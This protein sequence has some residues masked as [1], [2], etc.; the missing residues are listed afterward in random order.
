M[1]SPSI[2]R[3]ATKK[4]R[5]EIWR[6]LRLLHSENGL[7]DLSQSRVD[8]HLDRYLNPEDIAKDD[9]GDRG[10]IGVIGPE[11]ALE[12]CIILAIGAAWYSETFIIDEK[13]NFV[14]PA[15]R[16]SNHAK[17]LISYA[18]DCSLRIGPRLVIGILSTKRTEAKI[19]LY[20]QQGLT[21]YGVFFVY[22]PP[23]DSSIHI[24]ETKR[25]RFR[26]HRHEREI[27]KRQRSA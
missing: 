18:K 2:V 16:A 10:F 7:H 15:H 13:L 4:D 6:L 8:W 5:Q 20:E 9:M 25:H 23:A 22:P 12:G 19:R 17:A 11:G 14:D 26:P 24:V 21:P 1:T 3:P 27:I